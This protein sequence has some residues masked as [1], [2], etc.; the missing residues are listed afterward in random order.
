MNRVGIG[1]ELLAVLTWK[2][3]NAPVV[4]IRE[5]SFAAN[6]SG[7]SMSKSGLQRGWG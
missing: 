5:M 4:E 6:H 7:L 3:G 1:H 2:F